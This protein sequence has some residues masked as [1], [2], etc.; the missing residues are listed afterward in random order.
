MPCCPDL[1]SLSPVRSDQPFSDDSDNLLIQDCCFTGGKQIHSSLPPLLSHTVVLGYLFKNPLFFYIL[2]SSALE[3]GLVLV[4]LPFLE[5]PELGPVLKIPKMQKT[6]PG[7]PKTSKN[8]FRLA[9]F[10]NIL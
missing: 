8:Q 3:S 10:G 5:G 7:L 1:S 6:R 4:L 2:K 9:K